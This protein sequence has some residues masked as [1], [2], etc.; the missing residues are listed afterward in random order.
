M[1]YS[2]RH[3]MADVLNRL[4]AG[5]RAVSLLLTRLKNKD[6]EERQKAAG[7]LTYLGALQP[8]AVASAIMP[9]LADPVAADPVGINHNDHGKLGP[10]SPMQTAAVCALGVIGEANPEVVIPI[11]LQGLASLEPIVARHPSDPGTG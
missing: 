11:V 6:V 7:S 1:Q 8:A 3:Q 9:L 10:N 4:G 2:S 5:Q